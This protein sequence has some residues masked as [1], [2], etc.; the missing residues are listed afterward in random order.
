MAVKAVNNFASLD[1]LISI[2]LIFLFKIYYLVNH[3][4][5]SKFWDSK[6]YITMAIMSKK[7]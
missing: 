7:D 5:F 3:H 6:T 2:L 4:F 1:R